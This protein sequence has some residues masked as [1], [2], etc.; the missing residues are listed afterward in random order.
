MKRSE[1]EFTRGEIVSCVSEEGAEIA[2]G[3]VNYSQSETV[4]II[5]RA[6][7]EIESILGYIGD[8]ELIHR[9]NLILS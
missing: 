4:R 1:G 5:G 2:R 6:S 8:E 9:D 7:R 3:L